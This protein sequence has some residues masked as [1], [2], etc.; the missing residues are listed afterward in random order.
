MYKSV[1]YRQG[2]QLR[3]LS[4]PPDGQPIIDVAKSLNKGARLPALSAGSCF[5]SD[6]MQFDRIKWIQLHVAAYH[7]QSNIKYFKLLQMSQKNRN[8][9]DILMSLKGKTKFIT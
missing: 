9:Y 8:E 4:D 6:W 5:A 7:K 1:R 2:P 3:I